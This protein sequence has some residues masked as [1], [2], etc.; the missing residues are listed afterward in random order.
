MNICNEEIHNCIILVVEQTQCPPAVALE[1]L[2]KFNFD[3]IYAIIR[4]TG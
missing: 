3:I 1:Y 2:I 4:I